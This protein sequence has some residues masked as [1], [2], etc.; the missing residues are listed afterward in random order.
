MELHAF[1]S[2]SFWILF[3][4]FEVPAQCEPSKLVFYILRLQVFPGQAVSARLHLYYIQYISLNLSF[5][6]SPKLSSHCYSPFKVFPSLSLNQKHHTPQPEL[7]FLYRM[8]LN[9]TSLCGC[10]HTVFEFS[11]SLSVSQ[12]AC[13]SPHSFC[14]L[15]LVALKQF[16]CNGLFAF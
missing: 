3:V 13:P 1:L 16:A 8:S 4:C 9:V 11:E 14:R 5:G 10:M 7:V 2:S 6:L 12:T 15:D